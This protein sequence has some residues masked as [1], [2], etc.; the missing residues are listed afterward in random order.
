M[1]VI[2]PGAVV[3]CG[4]LCS[5]H[6]PE[7]T[8]HVSGAWASTTQHTAA[9]YSC[10]LYSACAVLCIAGLQHMCARGVLCR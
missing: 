10:H 9:I 8:V 6:V 2:T 3:S 1:Y 4:S 7:Q 5:S